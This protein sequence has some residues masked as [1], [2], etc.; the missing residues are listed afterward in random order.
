VILLSPACTSFDM[1]RS[2]A[3]RGEQF[4]RMA[5]AAPAGPDQAV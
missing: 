2:Y 1:F 4:S 5:N 3:D